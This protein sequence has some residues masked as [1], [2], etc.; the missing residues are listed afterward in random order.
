MVSV[1]L[2]QV[3]SYMMEGIA[4]GKRDEMELR[5]IS[6]FVRVAEVQ[7]FSKT[8]LQLGYSQSAVTMQIKQLEEE[9][10]TQLF[11]RIGKHVKLT[12]AGQRF[13]PRAL[14]VLEAVRRAERSVQAPEHITGSLRIGTSESHLISVLPPVIMEFGKIC[15][16]VEVSTH[17]A[18]ISDLFHMLKQ[19]DIDLLFFLDEKTYSPEW[20]RVAER[21]EAIYFV[22]SVDSDLAGEKNIPLERLLREPLFLTEKGISYRYA[23]EQVLAAKGIELHPFLETGNTDVITSILLR[24]RGISFL[25]E[26]VVQ[27]YIKKGQLVILDAECPEI[28]MW[29]Q[30]VYHKNKCVTL[31]MERFMELMRR[32]L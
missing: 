8:A 30:L 23:M 29:S 7:N 10:N 17:T 2:D 24:N 25:P 12:E 28:N 16:D 15:P 14:E 1:K 6:T 18:S 9:L 31:Q 21:P 26:Y 13:L 19:N 3:V 5:N 32:F 11:E 20:I 4:A 27:D 22:A